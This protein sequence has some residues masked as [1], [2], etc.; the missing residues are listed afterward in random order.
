VLGPLDCQSLKDKADFYENIA[1]ALKL[2]RND[3]QT[4]RGTLNESHILFLLDELDFG[5]QCGITHAD[6][7]LFRSLCDGNRNFKMVSVSRIPLKEVFPD[8]SRASPAFNF[9]VPFTLGSMTETEARRLLDHPWAPGA[10]SFDESSI[11]QLLMMAK[12][13]D[14]YHPFK[15]QRAAHHRF[16]SLADQAYDWKAGYRQDMEQML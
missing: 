8:T 15:L 4:I 1:K 10:L 9:L 3:W 14:G 13:N 5:S 11:D 12:C 6:L 2:D 16:E 7:A